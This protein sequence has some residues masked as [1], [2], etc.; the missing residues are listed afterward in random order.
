MNWK[1]ILPAIAVLGSIILGL[2]TLNKKQAKKI[3]KMEA[4]A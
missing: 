2:A 3:K 4:D 1:I